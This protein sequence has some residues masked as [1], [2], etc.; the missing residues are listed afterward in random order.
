MFEG[1]K[2]GFREKRLS[3]AASDYAWQTDPELA[4]LDAM[5]LLAIPFP[6]YL[7]SYA[8]QTRFPTASS[9]Q[10]SIETAD[11]KHIGNC[12]YYNIDASKGEAELGI[13]IGDRDYWDKG[14]GTDAV[15][16]LVHHIFNTTRLNR[17]HLKTLDWNQRAQKCFAKSGFTPCGKS[18]Q[19][20]YNFVLMEITRR[21]WQ[22]RTG[23]TEDKVGQ[24]K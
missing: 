4:K 24:T 8:H 1:N 7:L 9:H 23:T 16:A 10:F 22:E 5:P 6:E 3:D 13:M 20:A 21:Q 2:I 11:G 17:L 15:M 12:T 14:Y 19:D 18:S